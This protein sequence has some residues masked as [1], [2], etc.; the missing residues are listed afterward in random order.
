LADSN[1]WFNGN[2]DDNGIRRLL[3]VRKLAGEHLWFH[4]VVL[5][6]L[7]LRQYIRVQQIPIDALETVSR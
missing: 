2:L 7:Y 5:A 4:E 6:A 3:E 1:G